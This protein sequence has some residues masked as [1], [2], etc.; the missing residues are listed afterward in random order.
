MNFKELCQS[1]EIKIQESYESGVT[2]QDAERLA[3]EFLYA[4]LQV[5]NEL[6]VTDL[7]ARAKKAGVKAIRAA[8]YLEAA[9]KDPKKP[10]DVMLQALVDIS[11]LV[12]GEQDK[13]DQEESKRDALERYYNIFNQSHLHFRAIAKGSFGG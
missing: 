3:G 8:V 13:L 9:T 12:Q 5:S 10:S 7:D 6:R 11:D 4:L 1:L 2:L